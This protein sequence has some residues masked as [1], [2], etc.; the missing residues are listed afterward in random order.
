MTFS[1]NGFT[2]LG[3]RFGGGGAG[4]HRT[5]AAMCHPDPG[6]AGAPD[7]TYF[8]MPWPAPRLARWNGRTALPRRSWWGE[9]E[10]PL[11]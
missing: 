3:G 8:E 6:Y 7:T 11:T 9:A 5:G 1:M 10:P 4:R 2:G